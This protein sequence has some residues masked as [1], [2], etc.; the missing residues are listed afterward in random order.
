MRDVILLF[1]AIVG[2]W[3]LVLIAILLEEIVRELKFHNANLSDIE[4]SIRN[5]R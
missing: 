5:H 1:C 4:A 2:A 3:M